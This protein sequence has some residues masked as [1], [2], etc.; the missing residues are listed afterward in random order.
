R[1]LGRSAIEV[2]GRPR[3]GAHRK[4]ARTMPF[5]VQMRVVVFIAL[6]LIVGGSEM[7]ANARTLAYFVATATNTGNTLSTVQLNI[8][9][10]HVSAGLF[11]IAGNMLPG[12][13]QLKAIQVING[14]TLGVA[15]Q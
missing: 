7:S 3:H 1:S 5:G 4:G 2:D 10:N 8:S 6:A 13:F 11:N 15:Q 12:D 14:G 9:N